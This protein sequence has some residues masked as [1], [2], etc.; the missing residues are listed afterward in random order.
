MKV[1][2]TNATVAA[3]DVPS[4]KTFKYVGSGSSSYCDYIRMGGNGCFKITDSR[5]KT[6][7]GIGDV[8]VYNVQCKCFGVV[9]ANEQ[10]IPTDSELIING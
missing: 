4:G 9:P 6:V 7:G 1:T 5:G 10:V 2:R 3:R 8:L